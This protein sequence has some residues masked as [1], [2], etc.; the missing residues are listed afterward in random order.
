MCVL[1]DRF[2]DFQCAVLC[3]AHESV[4]GEK[5]YGHHLA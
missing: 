3:V 2:V 1:C 5:P 4:P